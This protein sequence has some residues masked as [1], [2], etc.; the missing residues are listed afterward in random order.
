[1]WKQR[2]G[3]SGRK[4]GGRRDEA[5]PG[6]RRRRR[7]AEQLSHCSSSSRSA[8]L[9]GSLGRRPPAGGRCSSSAR[10]TAKERVGRHL[11]RREPDGQATER[12]RRATGSGQQPAHLLRLL[13]HGWRA[14][15]PGIA[16][17]ERGGEVALRNSLLSNPGALSGRQAS[18]RLGG[19]WA[20]RG[21]GPIHSTCAL[22]PPPAAAAAC[23][24]AR[25]PPHVAAAHA[26]PAHSHRRRAHASAI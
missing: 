11:E 13:L 21:D 19:C 12:R 10:G 3:R 16:S 24:A 4:E 22:P 15:R 9:R 20:T 5:R 23:W 14:A 17:H 6:K 26:S 18:S 8:R 7:H 25:S 2:V 1:M